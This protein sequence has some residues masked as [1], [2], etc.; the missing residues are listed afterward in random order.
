M[1]IVGLILFGLI[2]GANLANLWNRMFEKKELIKETNNYLWNNQEINSNQDLMNK[3][4][5]KNN[6]ES[7]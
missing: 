7:I 4:N 2:I 1:L 3:A 5:E 6:S